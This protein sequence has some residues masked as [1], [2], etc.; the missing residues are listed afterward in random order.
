MPRHLWLVAVL[1]FRWRLRYRVA[2]V[3]LFTTRADVQRRAHEARLWL[4]GASAPVLPDAVMAE[5][6]AVLGGVVFGEVAQSDE[7]GA[8]SGR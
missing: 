5:A 2:A 8:G 7:I 1:V 6:R 3:L 4:L